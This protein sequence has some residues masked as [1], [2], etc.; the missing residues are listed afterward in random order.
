MTLAAMRARLEAIETERRQIHTEAGD[1][2][3]TEDQ[4]SRWDALDTEETDLRAQVAEAEESEA[5]A[6]RVAESRARWGATQVGARRDPVD[7][8]PGATRAQLVDAALRGVDGRIDGTD[9]Q[10][11]FEQI[12]RRHAG[13]QQWARQIVA[14]SH[15]DYASAFSKLVTGRAAFLTEE[16]KRAAIAVGTNTAG[17]F[18]VPTHLDPTLILTNAGTSNAIRAISRVVTLTDGSNVWNG[19]STAGATA[20]WDAE[21]TEVSDDTPPVARVS[22]P[23]F[24]ARSL[25]QASIEAFEDIS[26]LATDAV[27]IL[28][29]ARD[30]LEGAAHAV[31]SGTGQPTGIFTALDANT[32]VEIVSTTAATIGLVDIHN[33]YRSVP[34][35]WRGRGT[36]LMNPLYS[37]AIKALGSALS[38]SYSTDL[39][40]PIA[41]RILGRPVVE[42]D[43]APATQTTTSLD[44]EIV[45]GDFSNFVIVDK[46]GSA[47][48]EF[49][50]HM[51]NTSNNLPDGRRAWFMH[52]RNGSD[53][54]ND[55]AFRL[56]QDKT[57]A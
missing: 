28:N 37:L 11:H 9:N 42:S 22:V 49:I 27:M 4:Q 18:L 47:A 44:N 13:D 8:G 48:I 24:M 19:V 15:P 35:R 53:S 43:D 55:L 20:S 57:S 12:M 25:V 32:N 52:W 46:P 10:R 26:G 23:T 50:P 14:R 29:D 36:W 1:G 2:A 54:V 5:R 16:E 39:T 33:L 31:G 3:L 45:Y 40:Q 56:L 41:D 38:A 30:R 34:V 7:L 21:L 17:G 51:F 6:A